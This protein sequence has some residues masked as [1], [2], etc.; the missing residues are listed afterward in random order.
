MIERQNRARPTVTAWPVIGVL[1]LA[2]ASTSTDAN[3]RVGELLRAVAAKTKNELRFHELSQ[4][5]LTREPTDVE[6]TLRFDPDSGM[7]EKAIRL[8]QAMTL[9]INTD[10]VIVRQGQRQLSRPIDDVPQLAALADAL[11]AI[12]RGDS[13]VLL[14]QFSAELVE[15]DSEFTLTLHP[16]ID[17]AEALPT[18][19]ISGNDARINRLQSNWANGDWQ[20]MR[21]LSP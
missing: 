17:A 19:T 21:F 20:D 3:E 18:L 10:S 8:P 13:T 16:K 2:L 5:K 15:T 14:Q 11:R 4:H 7:L 9:T 12:L 6:G 1:C